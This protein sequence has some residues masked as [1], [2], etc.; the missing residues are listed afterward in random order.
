MF[1]GDTVP[2]SLAKGEAVI[3]VFICQRLLRVAA[4]STIALIKALFDLFNSRFC[5]LLQNP[6]AVIR[7][8]VDI[9][10]KIFDSISST[11]D[12]FL[13]PLKLLQ[14][15]II[16]IKNSSNLVLSPRQLQDLPG[17]P[18]LDS[19]IQLLSSLRPKSP[20]KWQ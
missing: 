2:W 11:M 14:S 7:L 16:M 12:K 15:R 17:L 10:Y 19:S 6:L 18:P 9:P 20:S 3:D 8:M 5:V 4:D 13:S 1:L